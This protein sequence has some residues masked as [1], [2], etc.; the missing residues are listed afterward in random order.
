MLKKTLIT[1]ILSGLMISSNFVQGQKVNAVTNTAIGFG[2]SATGGNPSNVV[3]VTNKAQL[4]AALKDTNSS[5]ILIMNDINLCSANV[6]G[7]YVEYTPGVTNP[8]NTA[9]YNEGSSTTARENAEANDVLIKSSVSNKTITGEITNGKA[10]TLSGGGLVLSGSN[11]VLS[12]INF[13]DAYDFFPVW[14]TTA[15]EWNCQPDNINLVGAKNVWVNQCTF[16]DGNNLDPTA[17]N[18]AGVPIHHD[19]LL[20]IKR[21]ADNITVSNSVFA[22]HL[23]GDLVGHKDNF[24][25]DNFHITY[26]DNY[27]KNVEERSP[28]IRSGY[29]HA[30][31]NVYEATKSTGIKVIY[32]IGTN[33]IVDSES[34][35]FLIKNDPDTKIALNQVTSKGYGEFTDKGSY[36]DNGTTPQA[37]IVGTPKTYTKGYTYTAATATPQLALQIKAS[38]GAPG[39]GG[40]NIN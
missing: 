5:T 25:G 24:P 40:N 12:N 30:F 31:N 39:F 33:G 20:D 14:D 37:L 8:Q 19:G 13:Q 22:N 36:V 34:N 28:R 23:K 9:W 32:G 38:A 11:L 29:A 6:N 17:A 21:G 3:K 1:L 4:I 35:M 15:K 27:Y 7:T 2:S 18:I 26:Y 16:S 10:P